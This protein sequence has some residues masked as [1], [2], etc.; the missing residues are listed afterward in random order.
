MLIIIGEGEEYDCEIDDAPRLAIGMLGKEVRER[1][2]CSG[3][4]AVGCLVFV[5]SYREDHS[6]SSYGF[7]EDCIVDRLTRDRS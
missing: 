6:G 3:C 4:R 2:V 7:C 5:E 1:W